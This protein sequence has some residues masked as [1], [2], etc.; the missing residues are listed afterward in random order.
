MG[1]TGERGRR[2]QAYLV[3]VVDEERIE[4]RRRKEEK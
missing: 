2:P 3:V 1:Q 4:G